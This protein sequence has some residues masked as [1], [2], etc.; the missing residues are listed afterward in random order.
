MMWG[1]IPA[2]G[3]GSRVSDD[4]VDGC[5]ELIEI[6]GRTMLQRTIDELRAAEVDGIVIVTSPNKPAIKTSLE[7]SGELTR[8]DIKFVEQAEPNGLVDAISQAIPICGENML[9]ATPDNLYLRHPC[10]SFEL[11]RVH[12]TSQRC[13]IG[14]VPVVSPWGEMLGDTGRVDSLYNSK[15]SEH[16]ALSGIL[17]KRKTKPFPLT[18]PPR[19]RC[20]GRMIVT[21]E[22]W[23][24]TGL[25]DVEKLGALASQGRLLAAELDADYIDIGI[26]TGLSYARE[27]YGE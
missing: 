24:Q 27:H 6:N 2:A 14:V 3:R 9:V 25:D 8:G 17:E 12:G 7:E 18:V 22:F 13:V 21:T 4:H 20:T 1:V 15:N 16:R 19:W 10:P 5:K 23:W 26:P 11:L